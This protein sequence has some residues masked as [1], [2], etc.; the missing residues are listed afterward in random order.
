MND[1]G[2][3]VWGPEI[4]TLRDKVCF[5]PDVAAR[6]GSTV[7]G[8]AAY[9]GGKRGRPLSPEVDLDPPETVW[10][11]NA[12]VRSLEVLGHEFYAH[13]LRTWCF[14]LALAQID[15][16]ELDRELFYVAALLHD[17]GLRKPVADRCFTVAGAEAAESLAPADTPTQ[18]VERVRSAILAHIDIT[19]P[20]DPLAHYL[21]AG[22]LLDVAGSR[23]SEVDPRFLRQT[24]QQWIRVGFPGTCR[25]R[26]R[27]ECRRFP[28]GR[29]AYARCPGGLLLGTRLN[30]LPS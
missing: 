26:W 22:S 18:D 20:A 24:C 3:T 13:S 29:A 5:L 6:L 17:I 4:L 25:S 7:W 2:A 1:S 16:A 23:I 19:T 11:T 8:L 28:R 14:G 9:C 15:G 30:A 12:E 10:T 27:E 21:Q